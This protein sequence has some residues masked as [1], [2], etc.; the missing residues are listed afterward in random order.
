MAKILYFSTLAERVGET[1]EEIKLPPSVEDLRGLLKLLRMRGEEWPVYLVDDR[2]QA[3]VNK[4]FVEL[5][6]KI[7]DRDEIGLMLTRR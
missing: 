6:A 5:D 4:N 7:S 3:T 2:I 1:M